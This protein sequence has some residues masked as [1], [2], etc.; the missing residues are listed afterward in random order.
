MENL[1]VFAVTF[2]KFEGLLT[3]VMLLIGLI[4][5]VFS[6]QSVILSVSSHL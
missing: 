2:Y 4:M 3:T 6:F 5:L 1:A